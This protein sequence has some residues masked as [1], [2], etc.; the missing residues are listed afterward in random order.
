[1][2]VLAVAGCGGDGG[3]ARACPPAIDGQPERRPPA[4][5]A[6]PPGAHVYVSEGPFG[7]TERF[8]AVV[9]GAVDDLETMRDT[10]TQ[11]LL[12]AGYK[13]LTKDAE[14]P[15]EAEGH[16]QGKQMVSVQV[17]E[18]CDGKLRLRYTVS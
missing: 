6:F 8:Y 16:V 1:M 5:L 11:A 3:A 17:T 12:D 2:A 7:K 15:I 10:A 18:L 9:D 4:E 14:P 13:L